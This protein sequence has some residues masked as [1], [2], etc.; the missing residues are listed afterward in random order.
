MASPFIWAAMGLAGLWFLVHVF[1][2]GRQVARPLAQA[3]DLPVLVRE[4]QYLCWHFTS[5]AIA[6]M[7]VFF[8]AAL[9]TGAAAYALAATVLAAAFAVVGIG[10]VA[11]RGG[12]HLTF[13]Q[14]WL[15]VPVA[16]LGLLGLFV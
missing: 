3:E 2:G 13:P 4:T 9:V 5:V 8:G 6:G 10:I 11:A 7:A 1:V 14:G 12:R 15:F 16:V